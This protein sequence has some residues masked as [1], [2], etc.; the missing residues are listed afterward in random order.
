MKPA[1][2]FRE[3]APLSEERNQVTNMA[4]GCR[5]S[6]NRNLNHHFKSIRDYPTAHGVNAE[7]QPVNRDFRAGDVRHSLADISKA[8]SLMGYT[9]THRLA[10]GVAEAMPWYVKS[11]RT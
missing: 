1:A 9:R 2:R 10:P 4:L 6:L 7:N 11:P 3:Q 8:Q 5:A